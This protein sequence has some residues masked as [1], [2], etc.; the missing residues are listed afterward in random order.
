MNKSIQISPSN[1][2]KTKEATFNERGKS[3]HFDLTFQRGTQS[4]E[5][6]KSIVLGG[7]KQAGLGKAF[8]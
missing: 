8:Y 1:N 2:I 7:D 6:G 4:V 3:R 5:S